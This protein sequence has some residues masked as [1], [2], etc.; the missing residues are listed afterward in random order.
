MSYTESNYENAVLEVF[1]DTL[2]YAY[3]YGPDVVRD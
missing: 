3:T 2:G 1:R